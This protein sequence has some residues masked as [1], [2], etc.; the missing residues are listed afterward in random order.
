MEGKRR[1]GTGGRGKPQDKNKVRVD[2]FEK[3]NTPQ[4]PPPNDKPQQQEIVIRDNNLVTSRNMKS[5]SGTISF[6]Y[7]EN[8]VVDEELQCPICLNPLL[9]PVMISP[10]EHYYCRSC[11]KD[12]KKCPTC[13]GNINS[14]TSPTR[15]VLNLLGKI[16]VR[17]NSC[18]SVVK[19]GEFD[20]HLES[21][22]PIPCPFGCEEKQTRKNIEQHSKV[23]SKIPI[24]CSAVDVGCGV[25]EKRDEIGRHEISCYFLSQRILLLKLNSMETMIKSQ[26][27]KI[28]L[29]DEKIR[30]QDEKI[31][32][33]EEKIRLEEERLN[34]LTYALGHQK[35]QL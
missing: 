7:L 4:Q 19:R 23:C 11:V 34:R 18:S 14:L 15:L 17:C 22:C 1:G 30:Q 21:Y 10:C 32:L 6:S 27:E 28:R 16:Q 31:R 8:S 29:Q 13:N 26:E 24:P 2:I 3:E 12:Q 33:Q 9:D 25:V 20:I 5:V 35:I